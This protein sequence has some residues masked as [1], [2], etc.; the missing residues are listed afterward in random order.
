MFLLS[1][2]HRPLKAVVNWPS[3]RPCGCKSFLQAVEDQLDAQ[4]QP[5]LV[6]G[7]DC[8]PSPASVLPPQPLSEM[9]G[10]VYGCVSLGDGSDLELGAQVSTNLP[11]LEAL[12]SA[13]S[14]PWWN[15]YLGSN[16]S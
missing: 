6:S 7:G 2:P 11:S 15:P 8:P 12:D 4:A 5:D 9:G 13:I 14:T 10:V 16:P 1:Q 3:S